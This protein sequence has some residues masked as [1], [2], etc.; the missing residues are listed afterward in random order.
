MGEWVKHFWWCGN[1]WL[2]ICV[3]KFYTDHVYKLNFIF[4]F[5]VVKVTSNKTV[6]KNFSELKSQFFFFAKVNQ[7]DSKVKIKN[8]VD[9]PHGLL[10]KSALHNPNCSPIQS[11]SNKTTKTAA[12]C[13][14]PLSVDWACP[15]FLLRSRKQ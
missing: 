12:V 1:I 7:S 15:P 14:P 3:K 13:V 9:G 2:N 5:E 10:I 6:I 11:R 8:Q 4:Y